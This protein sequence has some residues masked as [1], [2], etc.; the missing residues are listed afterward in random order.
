MDKSWGEAGFGS[1]KPALAGTAGSL[2]THLCQLP[3]VVGPNTCGF[4]TRPPGPLCTHGA[5][6]DLEYCSRMAAGSEHIA[7]EGEGAVL[8]KPL[9]SPAAWTAPEALAH[10]EEWQY[11]LDPQDVQEVL[12]A[13]R[14][15]I[16]TGKEVPVSVPGP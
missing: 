8:G 10:P 15:A 14:I 13:T 1:Q 12:D 16:S 7:Q 3:A 2:I 9:H 11:T 6:A 5:G 4:V